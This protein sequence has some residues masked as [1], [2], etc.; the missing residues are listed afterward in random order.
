M[1]RSAQTRSYK[2]FHRGQIDRIPQLQSLSAEQRDAVSAVAAVLPFR[3][4]NYVIDELIDWDRVPDDPMFQLTFPQRGM[5]EPEDFDRVYNLVRKGVSAEFLAAEA[6]KIQMRMNPHPAGQMDLNL[7]QLGDRVLRGMQ[8][9]YRQT[10]LFFPAQGQ[11][12]H[13]YCTYCFRWA[14]FVGIDELKFVERESADLIAYLRRNPE[15]TDVLMTGGDPLVMS[16]KVLRRYIDPLLKAAPDSLR[17]IRIG[18]KAPAYWP[19]R[20]VAGPDADAL[21]ELFEQIVASGR[22][23]ALMAHFSHPRELETSIAREAIRRIRSTGA[24][25]RCQAPLIR[26]VNDDADLWA[27]MWRHQVNLGAVPYYMFVER[28]TGAHNYFGVPLARAHRIY[29]RAFRQVSGLARTAR[30]PSMSATPGKVLVDGVTTVRGERVF[31]LKFLQGRNPEWA[32]RVFF[33]KYDEQAQWLNDLEP[34][35]GERQF[36]FEHYLEDLRRAR[37]GES[38]EIDGVARTLARG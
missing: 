11:T 16:T 33:A 1:V 2:V 19:Y 5:L 20:F 17:T 21:M 10:L 24:E 36:F 13:A 9:K 22:H 37:R 3:V 14:Q 23:L 38:D 12:C 8:H 26:R 32:N 35:F 27:T 29:D 28:D 25:V 31:V 34:A 4:N 15:V 18:T 30:G 7:P 6:R